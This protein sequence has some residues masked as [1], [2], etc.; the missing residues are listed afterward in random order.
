[1]LNISNNTGGIVILVRH[2]NVANLIFFIFINTEHINRKLSFSVI[3]VT[4]KLTNQ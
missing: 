2:L 4:N 3:K 1:M